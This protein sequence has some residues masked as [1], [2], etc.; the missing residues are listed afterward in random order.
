LELLQ[1]SAKLG[2][3]FSHYNLSI[4]YQTGGI[5]EKDKRKATYYKQL[6]AFFGG[7]EIFSSII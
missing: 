5:G 6:A 3:H 7:E 4:C 1:K 2:N